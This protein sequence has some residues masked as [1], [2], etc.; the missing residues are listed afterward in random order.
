MGWKEEQKRGGEVAMLGMGSK[1][2]HYYLTPIVHP[3]HLGHGSDSLTFDKN[4]FP[5][6]SDVLPVLLDPDPQRRCVCVSVSV[7]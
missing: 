5:P 2:L 1:I 6:S 4:R 3:T 7:A